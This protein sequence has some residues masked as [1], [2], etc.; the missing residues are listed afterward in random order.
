M[1]I[2]GFASTALT[3]TPSLPVAL[4]AQ[5][6]NDFVAVAINLRLLRSN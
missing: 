6:I 4:L 5:E 2:G 1:K 3:G